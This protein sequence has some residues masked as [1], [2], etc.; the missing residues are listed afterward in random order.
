MR[1]QMVI[2]DLGAA[3]GGW[4]QAA[5][6]V[7]Q[8][9]GTIVG[10]D[11]LKLQQGVGDADGVHFVQGDFLDPKVQARLREALLDMSGNSACQMFSLGSRVPLTP[12]S[13]QPRSTLS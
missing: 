6:S 7:L 12:A 13:L 1:P 5:D 9:T 8:G 10:V 2:V 4:I 11:L 3:P